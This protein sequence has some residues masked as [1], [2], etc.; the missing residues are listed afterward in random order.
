MDRTPALAPLRAFRCLLVRREA[1]GQGGGGGHRQLLAVHPA[2]AHSPRRAKRPALPSPMLAQ[3]R[4]VRPGPGQIEPSS[5]P[6]GV[7]R[8]PR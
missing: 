1:E 4:L 6:H 3:C 8:S 5:F 7:R 2:N